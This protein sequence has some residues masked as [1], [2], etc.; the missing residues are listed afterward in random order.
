M[1]VFNYSPLEL[2]AVTQII[3]MVEIHV[4]G[5]LY[6]LSRIIRT[7]RW[8]WNRERGLGDFIEDN[9]PEKLGPDKM[10]CQSHEEMANALH[11]E[12]NDMLYGKPGG[13]MEY[14]LSNNTNY[15]K[16][17]QPVIDDVI[18]R[19]KSYGWKEVHIECS[20]INGFNCTLKP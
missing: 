17:S 5:V 10:R 4:F 12:I 19:F 2:I 11:S 8:R 20:I 9:T 6:F 13:Q 18:D 1:E 7:N 14:R 15:Y 16:Y 3:C